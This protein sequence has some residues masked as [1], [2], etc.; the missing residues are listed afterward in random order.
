MSMVYEETVSNGLTVIYAIGLSK[1]FIII[2]IIIIYN[3][4]Q[5]LYSA[6]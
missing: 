2:I 6:L 3:N 4:I 5:Y 1:L